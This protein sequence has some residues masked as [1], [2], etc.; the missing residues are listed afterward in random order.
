MV[1]GSDVCVCVCGR[2]CVDAGMCFNIH[3]QIFIK[4]IFDLYSFLSPIYTYMYIYIRIP[5]FPFCPCIPVY[6]FLCAYI[7]VYIYSVYI[8]IY[9]SIYLCVG[10]GVCACV[11]LGMAFVGR[12]VWFPEPFKL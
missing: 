5:V 6:V 8:Y 9:L 10:E 11:A 4:N 7:C 2:V 1:Q 12:H 3:I